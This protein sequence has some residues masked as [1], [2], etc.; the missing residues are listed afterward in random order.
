MSL[1]DNFTATAIRL[2]DKFGIDGVL[3]SSGPVVEHFDKVLGEMVAL[4]P[5]PTERLIRAATRP[6]DVVDAEG[7][8]LTITE[9]LMLVEPRRG[10][11]LRL[12]DNT[13][14][15]GNHQKSEVQG[16]PVVY[17]AEVQ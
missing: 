6:V 14:T 12:G 17:R 13:Y 10:D 1:A 2:I 15:V 9:A 8:E 5:V 11:V 3:V 7:R 4:T 16:L